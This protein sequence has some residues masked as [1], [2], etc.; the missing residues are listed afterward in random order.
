[1]M[2]VFKRHFH[3]ARVTPTATRKTGTPPVKDTAGIPALLSLLPNFAQQQG[4]F[5]IKNL[6][7]RVR[8]DADP[9]C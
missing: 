1:M 6:T 3:V 5:G 9:E 7:H 2:Q 8:R 4:V